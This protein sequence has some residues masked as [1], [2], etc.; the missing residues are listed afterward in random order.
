MKNLL[1]TLVIFTGYA[2]CTNAQTDY[3][4]WEVGNYKIKMG[5]EDMFE[6]GL[7]VHNKKFHSAA[8]YKIGVSKCMS[9]P[10]SGQYTLV[11]GPVTF[12]Q[13]EGRPAGVDH[14]SDWNKNVMP[15]VESEGEGSYWRMN[16]EASYNPTGSEKFTKSRL[17][18]F[19]INPGQ[20]DRFK[21]L[22]KMVSEV[23][24]A[25]NY[26]AAYNVYIRYGA[27]QGPHA[28]AEIFMDSW[29]YL[30]TPNTFQKDYEEVHGEGSFQKFQDDFE[31]AIDRT[32]TYDELNVWK[33]ELGSN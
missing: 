20:M 25:K 15:Y 24:K 1:I 5:Q 30:D 3:R 29:A 2:L 10:S 16:D 4:Q 13:I 7:A 19:T 22:V 18:F 21:E 28:A 6:K 32:K 17:R 27:S 11:L 23:Y 12:S 14:D 9:G 33:P 31:I 8:P 26:K